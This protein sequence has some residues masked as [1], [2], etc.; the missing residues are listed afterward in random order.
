MKEHQAAP[1]RAPNSVRDWLRFSAVTTL[2]VGLMACA[3][4]GDVP[5]S[6]SFPGGYQRYDFGHAQP[7]TTFGNIE[8]AQYAYVLNA[9]EY[10]WSRVVP[11]YSSP[12][13]NIGGL[14]TYYPLSVRWRL[15]DGREFIL[16][17]ADLRPFMAT[18]FKTNRIDLP[19]QK[20]NRQEYPVGDPSPALGFE[21]QEDAVI[22]KWTIR[23]NQT[24][25]NERLTP[26]GAAT[27]WRITNEQFIV[28]R[29]AGVPTQGID[30]SK[31]WVF[32][33]P[34]K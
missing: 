17:R 12:S 10:G 23:T 33:Q 19:W 32:N 31:Q 20:E 1:L 21:I 26:T 18:Y 34:S 8:I 22:V 28:T 15:K 14:T 2:L 27:K 11:Y 30:F 16:D 13:P 4:N 25:P 9:R 5:G 24:P 3:T 29:I 7:A 6:N